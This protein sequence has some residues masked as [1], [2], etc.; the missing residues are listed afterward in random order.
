MYKNHFLL[1]VVKLE[2]SWS[3][4][5]CILRIRW[6]MSQ[7][8]FGGCP[9][10]C[11]RWGCVHIWLAGQRLFRIV[12]LWILVSMGVTSITCRRVNQYQFLSSSK[13]PNQSL[14]S[15]VQGPIWS[16]NHVFFISSSSHK[17]W[18][19][20]SLTLSLSFR[21]IILRVHSLYGDFFFLV[22]R[23]DARVSE[24]WTRTSLNIDQIDSSSTS[25]IIQC[26][27]LWAKL[28]QLP[29]SLFHNCFRLYFVIVWFLCS[30]SR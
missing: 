8:L 16:S 30:G 23:V 19:R 22:S 17:Y 26:L 12:L 29:I 5:V 11:M 28:Q 9:A 7:L 15:P 10:A 24:S 2:S 27:I 4:G 21:S 6:M 18:Y 20:L 3:E 25:S 13:F 14:L 1:L